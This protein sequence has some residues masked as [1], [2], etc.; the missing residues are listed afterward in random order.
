MEH[1]PIFWS[2]RVSASENYH[3]FYKLLNMQRF[4]SVFSGRTGVGLV[5]ARRYVWLSKEVCQCS[6]GAFGLYCQAKHNICGAATSDYAANLQPG[7]GS[8]F[9][10]TQAKGLWLSRWRLDGSPWLARIREAS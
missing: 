1:L 4:V 8:L 3:V 9:Q 6:R 7:E 2:G 10:P 5:I